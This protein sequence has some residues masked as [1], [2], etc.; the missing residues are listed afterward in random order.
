MNQEALL[1]RVKQ[2]IRE[3]EPEAEIIL[4]GSRSREDGGA[5]SDWDFLILVDGPVNDER[6]DAI[7]HLLYEIEWESGEVLCS[8][9]RDRQAWSSALYQAMPFHQNVKREGIVL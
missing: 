1:T 5:E 2:A 8:V 3:V 7:R 4:Y 6:T 9:V